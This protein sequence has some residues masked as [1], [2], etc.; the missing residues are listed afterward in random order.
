MFCLLTY[1][2]WFVYEILPYVADADPSVG[3]KWNS[4]FDVHQIT[5]KLPRESRQQH[6]AKFHI[7]TSENNS[8]DKTFTDT[9]IKRQQWSHPRPLNNESTQNVSRNN[10]RYRSRF[11]HRFCTTKN[12]SATSISC[13]SSTNHTSARLP[14]DTI[15]PIN[16][17]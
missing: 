11:P 1:F 8:T 15:A 4:S 12:D 13:S 3:L 2:H 10:K 5:L 14:D 16:S 6:T 7:Q 17:C 9:K